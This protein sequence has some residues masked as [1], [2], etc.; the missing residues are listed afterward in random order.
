MSKALKVG[1]ASVILYSLVHVQ[2]IICYMMLLSSSLHV[3]HGK[4]LQ[5]LMQLDH[6]I[7]YY[8]WGIWMLRYLYKGLYKACKKE[9]ND[10]EGC[11]ILVQLRSY[12][13][14]LPTHPKIVPD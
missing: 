3:M 4:Y 6:M 7:S 8:A 5:L 1:D 12:E 9:N 10:L 14:L 2:Y 11:A 13:R